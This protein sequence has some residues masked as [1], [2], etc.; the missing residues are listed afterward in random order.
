LIDALNTFDGF[1]DEGRQFVDLL[2]NN[3]DQQYVSIPNHSDGYTTIGTTYSAMPVIS[4]PYTSYDYADQYYTGKSSSLASDLISYLK[5][6]QRREHTWRT[7]IKNHT[8]VEIV[9]PI[10]EGMEVK[11]EPVLN[12]GGKNYKATSKRTEGNVTTYIYDYKVDY[13]EAYPSNAD[14][15]NKPVNT[16]L[17]LSRIIVTV[18]TEGEAEDALETVKLDI[19][20]DLLPI[21]YPEKYGAFFY[22]EDPLRLIFQVG[23][24]EAAKEESRNIKAGETKVYYTNRWDSSGNPTTEAHFTKYTGADNPNLY[25]FE[26]MPDVAKQGAEKPNPTETIR[27]SFECEANGSDVT[28]KLGNNGRL[29]IGRETTSVSVTKKWSDDI[30]HDPIT[31]HLLADGVVVEGRSIQLPYNGKWE[32]TWESLAKTNSDGSEIRYSVAEDYVPGYTV[33]YE[34]LEEGSKITTEGWAPTTTLANGTAYM[35]VSNQTGKVLAANGTDKFEWKDLPDVTTSLADMED[36]TLIWER[37]T[38]NRF[39]NVGTQNTMGYNSSQ[40]FTSN[41]NDEVTNSTSDFKLSIRVFRYI[42]YTTYYFT[43]INT[44]GYGAT[45]TDSNSGHPF[46]LYSWQTTSVDVTKDTWV[47]TNTKSEE[48]LDILIRKT[49]NYQNALNGAVFDLYKEDA[50]G[51]AVPGTDGTVRGTIIQHNVAV[52]NKG[53]VAVAL[54][55]EDGVYY[56][57]ETVAPKGYTILVKPIKIVV[58]DEEISIDGHEFAELNGTTLTVVNKA[59]YELPMTGGSGTT[60]YIL[61]GMMLML[62][63]FLIF[64]KKKI[65]N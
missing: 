14:S 56:L 17:D 3:F 36:K 26:N 61:G 38:N 53:E 11:G 22:E 20:E 51:N 43:D 28:Q 10:G 31:I 2:N 6:I 62:S 48:P 60:L 58:S 15:D 33:E 35:L 29:V 16:L 8:Q 34:F 49:D 18:T 59:A 46:T 21:F 23:L 4:N 57:I 63:T 42:R 19:P 44:Q 41:G 55:R 7:I 9:D 32:Y 5:S 50:T 65:L 64:I 25:P 1:T 40:N 30:D 12:F 39:Y 54:P 47:I 13:S 52:D 45:N 24:T 37:R 27:T